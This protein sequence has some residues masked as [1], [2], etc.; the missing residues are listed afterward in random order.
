[1]AVDPSVVDAKKSLESGSPIV[2]QATITA[3]SVER[4]H[5]RNALS[6]VV[7][8]VKALAWPVMTLALFFTFQEPIRRTILLIPDK[9]EKADK[10]NL[11]S[12]SWEIQ[13]HA[14][15]HGGADLARSVGALTPAAVQELMQTPRRATMS[16]ISGWSFPHGQEGYGLPSDSRLNALSALE[17]AQLIKFREPLSGWRDF[18]ASLHLQRERSVEQ[19]DEQALVATT[20]LT[21][22]QGQRLQ[23][24]FYEMT[25]KGKQAFDAIV[26]AIGAQLSAK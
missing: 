25:P 26:A 20:P 12:L 15:A 10:A 24:E 3:P 8:L 9:L 6:A 16:I 5:D 17:A 13:Q 2:I 1:M 4:G 22:A 14:E 11:G 18:V 21:P 19:N 7:D 23:G